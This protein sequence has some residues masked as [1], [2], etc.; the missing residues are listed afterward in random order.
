[1]SARTLRLVARAVQRQTWPNP[2]YRTWSVASASVSTAATSAR[3]PGAL[4]RAKPPLMP[5][6][7]A[8]RSKH[9]R[10]PAVYAETNASATR[11]TTSTA[12]S[13]QKA[14]VGA[15]RLAGLFSR[16]WADADPVHPHPLGPTRP[17][18][19]CR[20]TGT[21][22]AQICRYVSAAPG[23]G[24]HR[25]GPPGRSARLY[26]ATVAIVAHRL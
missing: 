26:T 22:R 1:M 5:A 13:A 2:T 24:T 7:F 25:R 14:A 23:D 10:R 20:Y 11:H 21:K 9:V 6:C 15:R 8:P 17:S 4:R 18:S 16:H 12:V 19:L 3:R